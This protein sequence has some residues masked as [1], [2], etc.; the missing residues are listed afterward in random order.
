[1][2]ATWPQAAPAQPDTDGTEFEGYA[3]TRDPWLFVPTS[4]TTGEPKYV[5]LSQRDVYLRSE[6]V[7]G[8]FGPQSRF[9]SLFPCNSRPFL[10]RAN[11][12]LLSGGTIVDTIDIGFLLAEKVNLVCASPRTAREWLAGRRIAPKIR[13]L[14]VSGAKLTD[15]V[16]LELLQ[17]FEMVEDVYGASETNKSFVNEKSIEEGRIVTRGRPLDSEIEIVSAE[18]EVIS[19][20]GI[21]GTVRVRNTY[22]ASGYVNDAA[23]SRKAF[24]DGWF[25]PGDA[26][27]WGAAGELIVS[28]R[29]DDLINLGG[30]K[31]DPVRIEDALRS[32][33]GIEDAVTFDDPVATN[34]PRLI[35]L[36]TVTDTAKASACV[37]AAH[38]AVCA[39]IGAH[40]A[41]QLIMVVP[42][43]P[44]TADGAPR[45]RVCREMA[46]A[47]LTSSNGDALVAT[48]MERV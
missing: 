46:R 16:A 39:Q 41:P 19:R 47:Y 43:I 11:A 28:G 29:L 45:R 3:D 40:A 22:M 9:C 6:A 37:A 17:S 10:A 48:D 23:S 5:A 14:Q 7:R 38:D 26:G 20:P 4:G 15:A 21:R 25:Y 30:L 31:I 34:P 13:T 35:A 33:A 24:R 32:V 42:E 27:A 2:D 12:S 18:G 36:V 44:K 1:M 8:D